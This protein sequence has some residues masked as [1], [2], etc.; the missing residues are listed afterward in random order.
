[1]PDFTVSEWTGIISLIVAIVF[2]LLQLTKKSGN[3]EIK[4]TQSSG[5]FSK[6]KQKQSV[7]VDK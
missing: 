6:G 3:S 7:K 5:D 2:G 4:I 1:M